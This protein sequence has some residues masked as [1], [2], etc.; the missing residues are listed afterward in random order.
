MLHGFEKFV[1][2]FSAHDNLPLKR[3]Q[4]PPYFLSATEFVFVVKSN[5]NEALQTTRGI[6]FSID[7]FV[8]SLCTACT[9][10][11]YR[12]YRASVPPYTEPLYRL[13]QSLCIALY[14]AS[15]SPYTE[16]LY[17]LIHRQ[18]TDLYLN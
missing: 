17:R 6:V 10:P 15:V 1:K 11:L 14:R 7:G 3:A 12:L 2:R 4:L 16:A 8:Q 18:C 5:E 9:E 13:V